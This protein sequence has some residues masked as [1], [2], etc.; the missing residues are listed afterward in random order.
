MRPGRAGRAEREGHEPASKRQP[1]RGGAARRAGRAFPRRH[2]L[3]IQA[4]AVELFSERGY[5]KTSL[6][7]IADRLGVTKAALYYHFRS[8]EDIVRSL[9]N[10]YFG[11]VTRSSPGPGSGPGRRPCALRS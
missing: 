10:D 1:S 6:R 9:V 7:E 8:K 2:A 5:D 4:V 11:Q 3:P